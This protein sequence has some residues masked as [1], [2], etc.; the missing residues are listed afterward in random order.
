MHRLTVI[1]ASVFWTLL[2]AFSLWMQRGQLDRTA[3]ALAK[4]DA[5]ANL[6]K[7]MAIRKWAGSVGG[8]YVLEPKVPDME[9]LADQERLTGMKPG[10]EEVKLVLLTPIHTLLAIQQTH[11]KEYGIKERLTSLQLRNRDNMPDE[12]EQN[13]LK[14]LEGGSEMVTETFSGK[15]G[16]GLTR[17]MIPMRMDKE[18]LECH[19]D[20]LVPIGGLRGGA[21]ISIDLNTYRTAQEPTWRVIQYWHSG[22]WGMGLTTIFAFGFIARRREVEQAKQHEERRQNELAFSAMAEGALITD[23][24]G[25]ILWVNDAFCE[26]SGYAHDEIIGQNPR[27]LKSGR[28]ENATYDDMWRQLK[29]TGHWRGELWNRRKSGEVFPEQIS[30]KALRAENGQIQRYI[31]VFSDI[32]ERK[33]GEEA[34]RQLNQSLEKRVRQEVAKNR[35]KDHILIQQSRL[36]AMGEMVHNIAHQWRQPLNAL[37]ILLADI[38]DQYTFN[39]LTLEGLKQDIGTGDRLIQKMSTT[40]DD[41][42]EFFQPNKTM[43]PFSLGQAILGSISIVETSFRH[44]SIEIDLQS[45]Q[46]DLTVYGFRNEFSQVL[47]NILANA[48]DAILERD[49]SGGR[50]VIASAEQDGQMVISIRDNAGGIPADIL[51]KIFDPYFTTRDKGTGIGLYMSKVIMD[52]MGGR[53]EARNVDGGAEI[54]V[55]VPPVPAGD[56]PPAAQ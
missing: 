17:V 8:V 22:V 12:W 32:T 33:R 54:L 43:E 2:I 49:I 46:P 16:H 6:R 19:R 53:I 11:Q 56:P 14:S 41:F 35:E 7:D 27:I 13:A 40:I 36:A 44:Y 1:L 48:K 51:P 38:K 37:S 30:I 10:G 39:E 31:A 26:I 28:H 47:L 15:Q 50:V 34:I 52:H 20:T 45:A 4:N 3:E 9:S 21:T 29:T 55:T 24:G 5:M 42:R 25:T 18:C 23:A